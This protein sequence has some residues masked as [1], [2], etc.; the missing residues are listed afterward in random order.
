MLNRDGADVGIDEDL[1]S[2]SD[3]RSAAEFVAA[4]CNR[5]QSARSAF[6]ACAHVIEQRTL[7]AFD[8]WNEV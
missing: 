8:L 4:Q 7:A 3:I 6:D 2:I 1:L 5:I